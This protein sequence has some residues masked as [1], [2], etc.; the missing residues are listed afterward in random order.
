M[1]NLLLSVAACAGFLAS[2]SV[3]PTAPFVAQNNGRLEVNGKPY[4]YVGTNFWYGAV[5]GSTGQG[6]NRERLLKELDFMKANGVGNLRVLVGADGEPGQ[7][8]KVMP[9]LQVAPGVYN[10]TIFDGLDFLLSEMG[11][12]GMYA[13]LYINN[14]WDWSGGYV[15]Y[16]RWTN[17]DE[18]LPKGEID[19]DTYL[20][21]VSKYA[22]CDSCHALF[23]NHVRHVVER[24]NR[25]TGKKY[26]DDPAIMSWQVGNEPRA[27]SKEGKPAFAKW[28]KEAI[29]LIRTLDGN[30]LISIGS[31]GQLG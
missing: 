9:T 22:T 24:T 17:Y 27:L 8:T 28:L 11:K 19:W 3:A 21:K 5:L 25:Y 4:Y 10:D 7:L 31:E 26:A 2:C 16:L 13:V 23:F 30:H 18:T 14:T 12:R 29:A 15:Q 6:G 1:K 20:S